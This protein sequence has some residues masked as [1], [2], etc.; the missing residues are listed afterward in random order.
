MLLKVLPFQRTFDLKNGRIYGRNVLT[1]ARQ[2]CVGKST[3]VK[4]V[5][6]GH[7][8]KRTVVE[9]PKFISLIYFK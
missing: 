2:Y 3:T 6:S 8:I 9:G 4:P 7:S 1:F 5:L